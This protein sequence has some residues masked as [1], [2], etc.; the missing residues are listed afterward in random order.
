MFADVC[1]PGPDWTGLGGRGSGPK[2]GP[3]GAA[4]ESAS[5]HSPYLSF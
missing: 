4:M 1:V 3:D 2:Q 5:A